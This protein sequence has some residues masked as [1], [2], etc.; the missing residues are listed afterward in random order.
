MEVNPKFNF[1]E[2]VYLIR[3]KELEVECSLCKGK[4]EIVYDSKTLVCPQCKGKGVEI[5]DRFKIWYVENERFKIGRIKITAYS[6]TEHHFKYKL[7]GKFINCNPSEMNM[8]NTITEAQEECN[9][10]NKV[11]LNVE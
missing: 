3:Q 1:N 7:Y 10:R 9:N 2:E 4:K 6:N 8:F 5:S 11:I